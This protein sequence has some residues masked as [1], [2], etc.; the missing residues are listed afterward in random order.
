M[1][2]KHVMCPSCGGSPLEKQVTGPDGNE[3][4]KK[5]CMDCGT[6]WFED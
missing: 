2:P 6:S 4:L 3:K 1:A 5:K